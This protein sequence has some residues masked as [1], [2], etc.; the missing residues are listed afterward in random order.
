MQHFHFCGSLRILF[1]DAML[2]DWIIRLQCFNGIYCHCLQGLNCLFLNILTLEGE[3][4]VLPSNARIWSSGDVASCPRRMESSVIP[5]QK[6][7]NLCGSF[8]IITFQVPIRCSNIWHWWAVPLG[9][10]AYDSTCSGRGEDV[11][12]FLSLFSFCEEKSRFIRLLCY[13][14]MCMCLSTSTY[15]PFDQFSWKLVRMFMPFADIPTLY[16]I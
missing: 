16:L 5:L 13:L 11:I 15:D 12:R 1:W 10:S 6:P 14:C 9:F 7:Q 4:T 2:H 3:G 8:L